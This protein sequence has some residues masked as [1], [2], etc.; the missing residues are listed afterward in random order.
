MN[1]S[2]LL[3]TFIYNEKKDFFI[4]HLET[5]YNITKN[6]LF[7]YDILE[8]KNKVLIT[9]KL[10]IIENKPINI[11]ERLPNT[12]TIHKKGN[13]FYTINAINNLISLNNKNYVDK[14]SVIIDWGKYQNKIMLTKDNKLSVFNLKRVF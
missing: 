2:T 8:Y 7:I 4:K 6:K 5:E 9:F 12:V 11:K 13:A 10:P 14:K 3:A 1:K